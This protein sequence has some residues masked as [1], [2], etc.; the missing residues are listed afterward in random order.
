M[1]M[2][3]VNI[4]C[5]LMYYNQL[6]L[7]RFSIFQFSILL[8]WLVSS[9]MKLEIRKITLHDLTQIYQFK[10][11]VNLVEVSKKLQQKEWIIMNFQS[12]I[13]S[14][15]MVYYS[16]VRACNEGI[17]QS[18]EQKKIFQIFIIIRWIQSVKENYN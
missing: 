4:V 1:E 15:N 16:G 14:W 9:W 3:I 5:L 6:K 11:M 8:I 2:N 18:D 17:L 13:D 10:I 7:I 12:T